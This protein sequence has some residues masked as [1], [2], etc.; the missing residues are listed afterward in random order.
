MQVSIFTEKTHSSLFHRFITNE[1]ALSNEAEWLRR[2]IM[3]SAHSVFPEATPL[4]KIG[5]TSVKVESS[6]RQRQTRRNVFF[7]SGGSTSL[8]CLPS[9]YPL[10]LLHPSPSPNLPYP[11]LHRGKWKDRQICPQGRSKS[12]SL[13]MKI[14]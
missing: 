5:V 9:P 14:V 7:V 13:I 10:P 4:Q 12:Y 1:C 11:T 2:K 6:C 8:S 3:E